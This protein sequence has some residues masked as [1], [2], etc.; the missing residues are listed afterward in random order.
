MQQLEF[1][2]PTL[3]LYAPLASIADISLHN[4]FVGVLS[5]EMTERPRA[6]SGVA[7]FMSAHSETPY[8]TP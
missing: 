5:R 8:V 1:A 4:E 7:A 6:P 2:V 3:Q